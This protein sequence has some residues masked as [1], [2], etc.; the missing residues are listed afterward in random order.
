MKFDKILREKG[1]VYEY[2]DGNSVHSRMD[3]GVKSFGG[4]HRH[5]D[6]YHDEYGV[7]D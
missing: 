5:M 7:R 6:Y 3:R 4:F 2:T 1:I